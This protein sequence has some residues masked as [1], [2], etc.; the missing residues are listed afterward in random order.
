VILGISTFI[1][2]NLLVLGV[3][4]ALLP[5]VSHRTNLIRVTQYSAIAI[6]GLI[7]FYAL[8]GLFTGFNPI[9]TFRSAWHNQQVLLAQHAGDRPYPLTIGFRPARFR[10]GRRMVAGAAG[11]DVP[12]PA[13]PG[14]C[15]CALLS[16][17]WLR[18]S[19][20]FNP[21]PRGPGISCC[22]CC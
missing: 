6:A 3:F 13:E 2:Y 21:R 7:A 10:A 16:R 15:C 8:L 19:A 22:R 20:S 1:T 12:A 4:L 18:R 5:F 14:W 17:S 9:A 11:G